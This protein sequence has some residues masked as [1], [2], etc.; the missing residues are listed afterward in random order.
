MDD[1]QYGTMTEETTDKSR[2]IAVGLSSLGFF[3]P[4]LLGAGQLYKGEK[5]KAVLFSVGQTVNLF[6]LLVIIGWFTYPLLGLI[7][8]WDAMKK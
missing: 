5:R 7:A 8:I 6:L 2:V 1:T 3:I 4:F